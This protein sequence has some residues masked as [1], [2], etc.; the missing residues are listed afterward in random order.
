MKTTQI[1]NNIKE[2]AGKKKG[3]PVKTKAGHLIYTENN[4]T[5]FVRWADQLREHLRENSFYT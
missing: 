2:K 5:N 1:I 4:T 3:P